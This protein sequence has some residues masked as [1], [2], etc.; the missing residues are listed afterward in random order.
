M[1]AFY[2]ILYLS[3]RPNL[4][5]RL[6]LG[7]F[8]ADEN[9]CYFSYSPEKLQ[10]TKSLLSEQAYSLVRTGLKSFESL[11]NECNV[12]SVLAAHKAHSYL[13]ESYFH[14]LSRY[15]NNLLTWDTPVSVDLILNQGVF[16]K[17]FEKF[18]HSIPEKKPLIK[19]IEKV[20]RQLVKSLANYVSFDV[21][22]TKETVSGLIVPAKVWFFGK[23]DQ[24]VTGEA[25]DFSIQAGHLQQQLNAHLF[26]IEMFKQSKDKK[27]AKFFMIGDEPSKSLSE[28]HALWKSIRDVKNLDLV[29][30]TEVQRIEEYMV[31][32]GVEPIL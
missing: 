13:K 21:E 22:L 4:G 27:D 2:S 15:S 32:H 20:K 19:P 9:G 26:L 23:N 3:I 16:N 8:M 30:T 31:D 29:P 18:V 1:K 6:S 14:Y 17:L 24:E 10:V 11:S 5:E 25:K 28:N 7:L 12:D